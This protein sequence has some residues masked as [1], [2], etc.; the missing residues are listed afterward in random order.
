[1]NSLIDWLNFFNE[2]MSKSNT[3]S[4]GRKPP[5]GRETYDVLYIRKMKRQRYKQYSEKVT[6]TKK[7][8]T[9]RKGNVRRIL[10]HTKRTRQRYTQYSEKKV[11]STKKQKEIKRIQ[12]DV[13]ATQLLRV[14][15]RV[16][17]Y[18]IEGRLNREP[19]IQSKKKDENETI[20]YKGKNVT[21]E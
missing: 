11:T 15:V 8:N 19:R 12:R 4:Q 6:S 17:A 16:H 13:L 20:I 14:A 2:L 5:S 9:I 10:Q 7:K 18:Y 21:T 1:M 3:W